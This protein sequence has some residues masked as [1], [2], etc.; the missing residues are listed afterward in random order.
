MIRYYRMARRKFDSCSW[1]ASGQPQK[2]THILPVTALLYCSPWQCTHFQFISYMITDRLLVHRLQQVSI[3]AICLLL[4]P[5]RLF[6]G[7]CYLGPE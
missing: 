7:K 1:Q 4:P 2:G 6:R 3:S 5:L